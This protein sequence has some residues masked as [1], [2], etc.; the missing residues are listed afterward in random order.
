MDITLIHKDRQKWTLID[1]AV[2]A[3]QNTTWTKEEKVEK[4]QELAYEIRR[5]HGTSKVT[6]I[7][8]LIG[9]LGSISKRSKA[10]FGKLG[11]P[12]FLKSVQLSAILGTVHLLRKVLCL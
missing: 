10:W 2:P 3:D 1:I 12:D 9:A 8:I 4:Y 6:M 5:I 11:V 7:P